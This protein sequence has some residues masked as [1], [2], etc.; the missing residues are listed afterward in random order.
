MTDPT[1]PQ[2]QAQHTPEPWATAI[3]NY[4]CSRFEVSRVPTGQ[5]KRKVY[6]RQQVA[7]A[8]KATPGISS[9]L[10]A[11]ERVAEAAQTFRRVWDSEIHDWRVRIL[12]SGV[13]EISSATLRERLSVAGHPMTKLRAALSAFDSQGDES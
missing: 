7:E 3:A 11:L 1:T 4:L 2:A 6:T 12:K 8:I 10:A 5:P 9:H 13:H